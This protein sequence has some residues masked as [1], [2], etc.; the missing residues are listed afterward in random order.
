SNADAV[1]RR[2]AAAVAAV[3]DGRVG[4]SYGVGEWP[5]DGPSKDSLLARAD[6]RLYAMKRTARS[7]PEERPD[8]AHEDD[9]Q[10]DR[11][12]CAGRLSA[13]LLPLVDP[14]EIAGAAVAELHATF[15]YNLALIARMGAEGMQ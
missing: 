8:A 14:R 13:K 11:L 9:R 4:V 12:A 2:A 10:R 5:A 7:G 3:E 15:R 6:D 1:G